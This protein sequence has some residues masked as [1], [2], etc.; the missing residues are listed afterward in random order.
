MGE[1]GRVRASIEENGQGTLV[2]VAPA[3]GQAQV[4]EVIRPAT[5]K[6]KHVIDFYSQIARGNASWCS[7][8]NEANPGHA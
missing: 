3:A 6:W 4:G 8:V 7:E 1:D 5:T 2:A